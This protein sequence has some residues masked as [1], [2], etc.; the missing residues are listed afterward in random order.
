M[1]F[2]WDGSTRVVP[3]LC[4]EAGT[5][6][7]CSSALIPMVD[8]HEE[9]G[10]ELLRTAA[11]VVMGSGRISCFP[12]RRLYVVGSGAPSCSAQ[13]LRCVGSSCLFPPGAHPEL[14][15]I[16]LAFVGEVTWWKVARQDTEV[17]PC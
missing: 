10:K 11:V 17:L 16:V 14:S 4:S 12:L 8:E 13:C 2:Y 7:L 3:S 15:P 6:S 1:G 9:V 5:C